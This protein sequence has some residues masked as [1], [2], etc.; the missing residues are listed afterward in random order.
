MSSVLLDIMTIG[1]LSETVNWYSFSYHFFRAQFVAL[2]DI[3]E[4]EELVRSYIN[5][6]LPLLMRRQA[7]KEHYDFLCHCPKCV[8]EDK[9]SQ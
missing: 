3:Q 8:F 5:E 2:R 1:N 7:L 4:G 9:K 6:D